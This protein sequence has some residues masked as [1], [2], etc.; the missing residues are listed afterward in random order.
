MDAQTYGTL[1]GPTGRGELPDHLPPTKPLWSEG[2]P[3]PYYMQ[4]EQPPLWTR[5]GSRPLQHT[6]MYAKGR[7]QAFE[8]G[9]TRLDSVIAK[10]NPVRGPTVGVGPIGGRVKA[11]VFWC[12]SEP[13]TQKGGKKATP[14]INETTLRQGP[15]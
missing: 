7:P 5:G 15:P 12:S 13:S 9:W 3:V 6:S 11:D 10:C 4:T 1:G 2:L 14:V 8:P